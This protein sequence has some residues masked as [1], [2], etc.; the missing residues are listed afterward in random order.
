MESTPPFTVAAAAAAA[1]DCQVHLCH[2][3][4][5]I[6]DINCPSAVF[7]DRDRVRQP[8]DLAAVGNDPQARCR[9]WHPRERGGCGGGPKMTTLST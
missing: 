4:P 7:T 2:P 1:A 3:P 9:R 8:A 6:Y 5:R